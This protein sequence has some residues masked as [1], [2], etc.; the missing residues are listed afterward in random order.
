MSKNIFS[1][2]L[3]S[4]IRLDRFEPHAIMVMEELHEW[5]ADANKA[6]SVTLGESLSL[7]LGRPLWSM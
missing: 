1:D 2:L 7:L 4:S 3:G 6:L 5:T